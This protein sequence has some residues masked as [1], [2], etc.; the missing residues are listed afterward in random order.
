M[1]CRRNREKGRELAAR[2]T[3]FRES[4]NAIVHVVAF[5]G[6]CGL[7]VWGCEGL[8]KQLVDT[9][10]LA[11]PAIHPDYNLAAALHNVRRCYALVSERDRWILGLG[12]TIFGTTD[13]RFASSAGRLG[14]RRPAGLSAAESAAY[15][16][17]REVRWTPA[18]RS[19]GH[20]GGH[21]GW[22]KVQFLREHLVP[23]LQGSP[24]LSTH[25][26]Q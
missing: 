23:L 6:G 19:M 15:D 17:L 20:R 13:R 18:L 8:E 22:A 9:L 14:F 4:N 16:R 25:E 11:A 3:A 1:W 24:Q 2:I 5:S 21:T 12:T 7:A 10:I 26:V